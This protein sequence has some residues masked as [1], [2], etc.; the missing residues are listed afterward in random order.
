MRIPRNLLSLGRMLPRILKSISSPRR[1]FSITKE[2]SRVWR[3]VIK[4]N[5][6]NDISQE[7]VQSIEGTASETA[8][9]PTNQ[10]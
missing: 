9:E 10:G 5:E 2:Q 8:E 4:D 6:A 1:M 3:D 7:N